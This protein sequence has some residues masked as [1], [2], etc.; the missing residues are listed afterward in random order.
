MG[1]DFA[2]PE[3][4]G[5][6]LRGPRG[7]LG[8]TPF[9]GEAGGEAAP[10]SKALGPRCRENEVRL[11]DLPD[12]RQ[13]NGWSCGSAAAASVAAYFGAGPG[14]NDMP[15]WERL[16]GTT[17]ADGTSPDAIADGLRSLGLSVEDREGMTLDDL[18]AA[19]Q[20]GKPTICCI[21]DY[22][23]PA[24]YDLDDS[25]HWVVVVG[26]WSGMVFVQDLSADNVLAGSGS[27]A[28]PGCV[29]ISEETWLRVW[30]DEDGAGRRY[31]RLG[32]I[33]G[34]PVGRTVKEF[35]PSEPRDDSGRW[36]SGGGSGGGKEPKDPGVKP[37][38]EPR[39]EANNKRGAAVPGYA[40]RAE[41]NAAKKQA[42]A[43]IAAAPVPS[44]EAVAKARAELERAKA[45]EGRA[46]GDSRGGSAKDRRKQREN[47]FREFG[48]EEKGYI[49][50]PHCGLK[51]HKDHDNEAGLPV[52][53][54]GKIF[55]KWAG[56][57]YQLPNLLAECFSC[58]RSRND[59]PIRKENLGPLDSLNG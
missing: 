21:Q 41:H 19:W 27:D 52:F 49:V 40:S 14:P 38:K 57:G 48:G 17:E 5:R 29:M 42:A 33:V 45:G 4:F 11:L 12:V 34:P 35:D 6:P 2:I 28:A 59:Q 46:G 18:R 37:G 58:N 56:G 47:L 25:G 24:A 22:R 44:P 15:A 31:D 13:P 9:G 10:G 8:D 53:E 20:A 26:L 3:L 55:T 1:L 54:R 51:C 7:E 43:K 36:T 32:L 23:D 39:R 50:C 30:H 16:L